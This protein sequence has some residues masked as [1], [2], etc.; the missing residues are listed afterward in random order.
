MGWHLRALSLRIKSL[1]K[2]HLEQRPRSD[3]DWQKLEKLR[4]IFI[5]E[6]STLRNQDYWSDQRLLELYD[7]TFA[8]RIATKWRWVLSELSALGWEP[9]KG[10]LLDWGCGTG[11][12]SRV[13]LDK[14]PMLAGGV[15]LS[16]RSEK[17]TSFAKKMI[18]SELQNRGS[19][20]VFTSGN[21]ERPAVQLI[22]HV[23]SE[24]SESSFE[25]LCDG[26]DAES[27][28]WVEPG[29][30]KE[31]HRL[32]QARARLLERGY[33]VVA[34]CFHAADCGM[35]GANNER[36]WCHFFAK[37]ESSYFTEVF[38]KKFADRFKIDLYS[39]PVSFLVLDHR[40][41]EYY[42]SIP[43]NL[44]RVIGSFRRGKAHYRLQGCTAQGI[45]EARL[46]QRNNKAAYKLLDKQKVSTRQLWDLN[47]SEIMGIEDW[48]AA[49]SEVGA[50][51]DV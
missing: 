31:S 28:I 15:Y 51:D 34:P 22:S 14:F 47:G 42:Q 44:V 1:V 8:Q 16:D 32:G 18:D 25:A 7:A 19:L 26:I 24:L 48:P 33:N 13:V 6:N 50:H 11:V 46:S 30:S 45:S 37:P 35:L 39:L 12:A 4:H 2:I 41:S 20:R 17:S 21:C 10:D 3:V 29:T 23:L 36:D 43:E 40:T 38:W 5:S 9:P 27:L 49:S